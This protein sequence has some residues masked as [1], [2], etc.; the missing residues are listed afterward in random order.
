MTENRSFYEEGRQRV[1]EKNEIGMQVLPVSHVLNSIE[2]L[3][4]RKFIFNVRR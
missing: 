2:K 1:R 3:I 4:D